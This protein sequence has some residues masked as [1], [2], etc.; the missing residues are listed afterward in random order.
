MSESLDNPTKSSFTLLRDFLKNDMLLNRNFW[1][2]IGIYTIVFYSS[3]KFF[4]NFY[5]R[6]LHKKAIAIATK[7]AHAHTQSKHPNISESTSKQKHQKSIKEI[8]G[9]SSRV[10]SFFHALLGCIAAVYFFKKYK[11]TMTD[12]IHP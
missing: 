9:N 5:Y 2:Y 1:K 4:N 10:V 12:L 3:Y 8:A 7:H 11:R 6:K